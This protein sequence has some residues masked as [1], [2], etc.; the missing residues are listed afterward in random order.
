MLGADPAC[1]RRALLARGYRFP[2]IPSA[3]RGKRPGLIH[4]RT[5]GVPVPTP[6]RRVTRT[7][8][9]CGTRLRPYYLRRHGLL[10]PDSRTT[11]A[12]HHTHAT[13]AMT[14]LLQEGPL[15]GR[16]LHDQLGRVGFTPWTIQRA[17]EH[18]RPILARS[19]DGFTIWARRPA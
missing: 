16:Y 8:C 10:P 15:P 1:L 14:L 4:C 11:K 7:C 13:A 9:A 2:P 12:P 19:R 17:R 6:D 5:C 18:L 3:P